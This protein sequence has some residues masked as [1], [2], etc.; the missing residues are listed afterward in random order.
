MKQQI[1]KK[2]F[3]S[4]MFVRYPGKDT[5]LPTPTNNKQKNLRTCVYICRLLYKLWFMSK[6]TFLALISLLLQ[7]CT[8][9]EGTF[10]KKTQNQLKAIRKY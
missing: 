7:Y 8:E 3:H 9:V 5:R 4:R 1:K 10:R 2:N 6:S